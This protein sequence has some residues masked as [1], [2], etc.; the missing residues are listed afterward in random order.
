MLSPE[1]AARR[2]RVNPRTVYRWVEVGQ[3][4][5]REIENGW[6][7]V[8]LLSLPRQEHAGAAFLLPSSR[9]SD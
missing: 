4:H 2:L 8:C 3:A 1:E 9:A 7:L 5:Y 6:L